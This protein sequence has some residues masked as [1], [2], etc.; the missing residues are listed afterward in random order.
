MNT[1]KIAQWFINLKMKNK[2]CGAI[3]ALAIVFVASMLT[4]R[5]QLIK[6]E[7]FFLKT[8]ES[9]H[10]REQALRLTLELTRSVKSGQIMKE[11][12]AIADKTVAATNQ[13]HLQKTDEALKLE[14]TF[15]ETQRRLLRW[16]MIFTLMG[17]IAIV[18]FSHFFIQLVTR[19]S[20]ELEEAK[21]SLE[22]KVKTRT[23][24][25]EQ[26]RA[27][28]VKKVEAVTHELK[29][30]N[31]SLEDRINI[32]TRELA[33]RMMELE[34]FNKIAIGRELRMAELKRE[35]AVLKKETGKL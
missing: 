12:D 19:S 30:I 25:L 9:A 20:I 2:L 18:I 15:R 28:L 13:W 34:Q 16:M 24:E 35:I 32:R 27:S 1:N 31:E 21:T 23:L 11:L 6:Q 5:S 17:L 3:S 4:L 22:E 33:D 10:V 14:N 26:E 8:Q 7:E 29:H